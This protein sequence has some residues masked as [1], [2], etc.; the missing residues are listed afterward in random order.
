M[1]VERFHPADRSKLFHNYRMLNGE[2]LNQVQIKSNNSFEKKM[3]AP[4]IIKPVLKID[5]N[6][7]SEAHFLLSNVRI[8]ALT[9][10]LW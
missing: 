7:M 6:R 2:Q 3:G 1:L 10:S 9:N 4:K 5:P 8:N